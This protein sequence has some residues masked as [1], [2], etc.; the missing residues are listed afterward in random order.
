ME[1]RIRA[2]YRTIQ[3]CQIYCQLLRLRRPI[4]LK[5]LRV[6]HASISMAKPML[7]F[8]SSMS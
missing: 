4:F 1:M 8:L 6:A 3:R 7:R 2:H 5:R